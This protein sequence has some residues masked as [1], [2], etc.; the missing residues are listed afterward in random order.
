MGGGRTVWVGVLVAGVVATQVA[1]AS[2]GGRRVTT[3]P[4]PAP[5]ASDPGRPRSPLEGDWTLVGLESAGAARKVTGF[6]RF[7]RFANI[8]VHA[9]LAADEPSARPPRTVLASFTAKALP[10][11]S[12]LDYAGLQ[13]VVGADRLTEDAVRMDAWR[14]YDVSGDTLRLSVAGGGAT[15]VFRRAE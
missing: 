11:G 7:D 4:G 9:E 3:G 2:G 15:L 5:S 8:S 14:V 10:A 1:C 12:E 13:A 6:L